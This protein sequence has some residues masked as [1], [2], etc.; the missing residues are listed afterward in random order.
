[1]VLT[2]LELVPA[3]PEPFRQWLAAE[4]ARRKNANHRYSLRAFASDLGVD[5]SSLSQLLRGRR[6]LT[7]NGI[8]RLVTKLDLGGHLR[9][10]LE[11]TDRN[12]FRPNIIWC[13]KQL[14]LT[15][16]EVAVALQRLI[17][18]QLLQMEGKKWLRR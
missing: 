9:A 12:D 14:G 5:H 4:F 15:P 13:A 10:L 16:D 7:S 6:T 3:E 18:A 17:R 8:R 2:T 1:M 11:L